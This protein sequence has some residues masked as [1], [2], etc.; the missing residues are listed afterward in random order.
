MVCGGGR[1]CCVPLLTVMMSPPLF[2]LSRLRFSTGADAA[3]LERTSSIW[4]SREDI[5]S[6]I[7]SGSTRERSTFLPT[8]TCREREREERQHEVSNGLFIV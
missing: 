5:S 8:A 4:P 7:A 2:S 1:V 3:H 6:Y